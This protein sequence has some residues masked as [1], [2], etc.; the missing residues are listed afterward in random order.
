MPT[1]IT[2]DQYFGSLFDGDNT[3]IIVGMIV[4]GI[5]ACVAL[6]TIAKKGGMKSKKIHF[7]NY[8]Q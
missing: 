2:P 5:V 3:W 6:A 4:L 8:F 7:L 1:R